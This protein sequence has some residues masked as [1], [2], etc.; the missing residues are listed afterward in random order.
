[1]DDYKEAHEFPELRNLFGFSEQHTAPQY[2]AGF[3]LRLLANCIDWFFVVTAIAILELLLVI[4]MDQ[5]TQTIDILIANVVILPLIKF[6][7]H[8]IMEAKYQATFGKRLLDIKVTDLNGLQPSFNKILIR[9]LSKTV[10]TLLLFF[11]Y[12]YSFLNKKQQCLHD[13]IAQTL[14]IKDR[15]I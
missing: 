13:V 11:G 4:V 8:I 7:Y 5:K 1:M 10:S 9:N 15:L 6:F 12:L 14:V 2:F 3:D